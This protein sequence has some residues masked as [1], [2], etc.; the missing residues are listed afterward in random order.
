MTLLKDIRRFQFLDRLL[1]NNVITEMPLLM[2][3]VNG[4]I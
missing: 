3:N 1:L 2:D 4:L